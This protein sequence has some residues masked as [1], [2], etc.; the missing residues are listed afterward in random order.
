ATLRGD[1]G[2]ALSRLAGLGDR[3]LALDLTLDGPA[4][5]AD[6]T[7]SAAA[8]P[9]LEAQVSGTV[10]APDTQ[11]LGA[12]LEGRVDA[13]GLVEGPL[14]RLAGPVALRLDAGRM[15]DGLVDLR[16][17]RLAGDAGVVEAEGRLDL[18][19]TRSALRL[20]AALPAS[21]AYAG[22]IPDDIAG[23]DALQAEGEVSG[24]LAAPRVA[25]TVEPTGF[26]SS[27][28]ALAALLG[29]TPRLVLRGAA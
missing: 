3:P 8:G 24:A 27:V 21:T 25:L 19:G 17:L 2:G 29:P 7:L 26:R 14:A 23:W 18:E 20:R 10:S 9:G 12:T 28:A 6:V 1:P 4:E 11:R 22:L 15:A 5:R 16:A 13:S